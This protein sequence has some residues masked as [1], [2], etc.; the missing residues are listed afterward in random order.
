MIVA[1]LLTSGGAALIASAIFCASVFF[2]A[3][4]FCAVLAGFPVGFVAPPC[5]SDMYACCAYIATG[6]A[7]AQ[8][9]KSCA[10]LRD[11]TYLHTGNIAFDASLR[12]KPVSSE[13][14]QCDAVGAR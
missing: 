3:A 4:G 5:V 11:I 9:T 8:T 6:A 2:A 1:P 14:R 12:R 13:I 10:V 7:S